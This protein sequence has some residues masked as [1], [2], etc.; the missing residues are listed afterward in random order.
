MDHEAKYAQRANSLGI[1][2]HVYDAKETA[3]CDPDVNMNVVGSVYFPGDCH[4]SPN[5]FMASLLNDCVRAGVSFRWN[6]DVVELKRHNDKI[7][8]IKTTQ[9]EFEPGEV[10]ICGGVWSPA[11]AKQVGLRIPMQAGKGYS[12][13]LEKPRQ[14]PN[15]CGIFTEA[16][17][18]VTP[19]NGTLRFGGTMEI[20]GLNN[21]I[22]M[23]RVRGIIKSIPD[24]YP[25][26]EIEDF[27]KITPW[28]G[29]RPCSPD[30]LPFL[31]RTCKFKN[32]MIATGHAMMG[33]SLAP[34]TGKLI[35]EILAEIKP[36]IDISLLSP[37]RFSR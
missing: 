11:L 22:N 28:Q 16:R 35:A 26:F 7:V 4:L 14:I 20:A 3:A 15:L 17:I 30:G 2:A 10:V 27:D 31:G 5:Q 6:T 29:L 19:M 23:R 8:S 25:N 32:L 21:T 34:I 9:E 1:Q 33:L 12:L 36:S 13:T 24:Y 37:D 18:A